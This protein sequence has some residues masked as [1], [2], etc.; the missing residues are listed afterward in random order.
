MVGHRLFAIQARPVNIK[1]LDTMAVQCTYIQI[2]NALSWAHQGC[3]PIT[4]HRHMACARLAL[5]CKEC[6]QNGSLQPARD[7]LFTS[8]QPPP[9]IHYYK[10]TNYGTSHL[11]ISTGAAVV[12]SYSGS[13]NGQKVEF[14]YVL[15][16]LLLRC[17]P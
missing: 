7:I 2:S 11:P 1:C 16:I 9:G 15:L 3:F 17:S 8:F 5:V 12:A 6:D 4:M 13:W 10:T 14:N